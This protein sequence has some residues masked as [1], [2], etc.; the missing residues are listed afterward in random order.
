M[1]KF[2]LR[3]EDLSKPQTTKNTWTARWHG[4]PALFW[5]S[6]YVANCHSAVAQQSRAKNQFYCTVYYITLNQILKLR[7]D[8]KIEEKNCRR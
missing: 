7:D 5:L 2:F 6:S 8:L 1:C 4:Q 3:L